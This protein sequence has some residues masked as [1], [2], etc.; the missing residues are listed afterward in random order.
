V[1][2]LGS[3][4]RLGVFQS[5]SGTRKTPRNRTCT[6][7]EGAFS[8]LS[9]TSGMKMANV[10]RQATELRGA[11]CALAKGT[12]PVENWQAT[13]TKNF[14]PAKWAVGRFMTQP[15][16]RPPWTSVPISVSRFGQVHFSSQAP[17]A[18]QHTRVRP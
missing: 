8:R 11:G 7:R 2:P 18:W 16:Q 12:E 9:P 4:S 5:P 3:R 13:W 17:T 14:V 10:F 6:A 15:S 1:L